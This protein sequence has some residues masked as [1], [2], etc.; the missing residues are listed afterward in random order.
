[1]NGLLDSIVRRHRGP[2]SNGASAPMRTGNGSSQK[3]DGAAVSGEAEPATT[4]PGFLERGR[5]RRR[6]RYLR[7]LRDFQLR[8]LGGFLVEL[9]RHGFERPELLRAK[10]AE[11]AATDAELR[12]LD[13]A[14]SGELRLPGLGG[15]C[16]SCGAVYGSRDRFCAACGESVT[17]G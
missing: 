2:A 7:Q 1:M 5:L 15:S 16:A 10:V 8:D 9:H 12:A 4:Q 3:P 17:R 6:A 11:A 13:G 14:I